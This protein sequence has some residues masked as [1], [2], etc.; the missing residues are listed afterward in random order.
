M[1]PDGF[2][3]CDESGGDCRLKEERPEFMLPDFPVCAPTRAPAKCAPV[4]EALAA[5]ELPEI[6]RRGRGCVLSPCSLP[7]ASANVKRS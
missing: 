4:P 5:K 7:S 3:T 2:S 1:C 6:L